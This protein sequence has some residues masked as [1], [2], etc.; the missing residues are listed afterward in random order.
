MYRRYGKRVLDLSLTIPALIIL[1]PLLLVLAVL[2]RLKLGSPVLFR[3]ERPGLHG[4]P[5][6]MFK[7]R[8][9]TDARDAE[10]NLLPDEQRMHPFGLFLRNTSL[11]ELPE[12]LLVLSGKLSLVGP[13]PLLMRYLPRYSLEQRRRHDVLPGIT[14]WAQINGRNGITW[15]EKF[16]YDVWYVENCSFWLDLKIIF[17]TLGKVIAR[18]GISTEGYATAPE[19]L[20]PGLQERPIAPAYPA[21]PELRSVVHQYDGAASSQ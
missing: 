7:F 15:D 14:G 3:Q 20:G 4:L 11:D 9:M 21:M 6:T 19:F 8:T 5:F 16:A 1:S 13:R 18:E 17:T 12:L 10:G 2:V